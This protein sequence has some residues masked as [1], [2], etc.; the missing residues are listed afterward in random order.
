MAE[1]MSSEL[2]MAEMS[3]VELKNAEMVDAEVNDVEG[4]RGRAGGTGRHCLGSR[5]PPAL[6][7]AGGPQW[8]ARW[9]ATCV[10]VE[11]ATEPRA[12]AAEVADGLMAL[13]NWSL[14]TNDQASIWCVHRTLPVGLQ[15]LGWDCPDYA[16]T[17]YK[18]K[19]YAVTGCNGTTADNNRMR[20]DEMRM[21]TK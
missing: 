14:A 2:M 20:G 4:M 12:G 18:V 16:V 3:D 10:G 17:R 11:A 9:G 8:R 13:D 7:R 19:G 6:Q 21:E 5:R 1:V 15:S